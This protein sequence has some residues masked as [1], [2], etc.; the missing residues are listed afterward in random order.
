VLTGSEGGLF[1]TL[2]QFGM[3][4]VQEPN[5]DQATAQ[6]QA[7]MKDVLMESDSNDDSE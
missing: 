7:S 4:D 6:T 2:A 5:V 1:S 3:P